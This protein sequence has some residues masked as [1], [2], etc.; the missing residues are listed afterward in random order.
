M[1]WRAP[2]LGFMHFV[3]SSTNWSN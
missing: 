1:F 3:D 2:L